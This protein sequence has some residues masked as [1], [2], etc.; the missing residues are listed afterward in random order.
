MQQSA[1][2]KMLGKVSKQAAKINL[3][4]KKESS[5]AATNMNKLLFRA[6]TNIDKTKL[7]SGRKDQIKEKPSEV[8]SFFRT[9]FKPRTLNSTSA[10]NNFKKNF[11]DNPQTTLEKIVDIMKKIKDR[12]HVHNEIDLVADAEW[13][14]KEILTNNIYKL[15]VEEKDGK[16]DNG[17]FDEYSNI[18]SEK[19]F[20][21]D[22]QK[23]G[24]IIIETL[25]LL[26]TFKLN[27]SF[28]D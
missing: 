24:N 14:T 13:V 6:D 19:L 12:L 22:I 1:D 15:K 5:S 28:I 20:N 3:E 21:K 23:S 26:K 18:K 27:L 4:E 7:F 8:T 9:D 16:E 17:F 11:S 2:E 10:L 25:F